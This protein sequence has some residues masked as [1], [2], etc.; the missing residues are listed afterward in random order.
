[1]SEKKLTIHTD[2]GS[3]G[4]PGPAACAFIILQDNKVIAENAVSLGIATNNHAEYQGVINALDHLINNPNLLSQIDSVEFKL[5]SELVVRQL[6]GQYKV[7][8]P[9][10]IPLY[11]KVVH[12]ISLINQPISFSH[13]PR[14]ENHLADKKLNLE[15]DSKKSLS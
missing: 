3:R 2:G 9:D 15:L 12:Q 11:Q 10:I 4:N 7:K 6:K 1:M 5:D 13:I 8:H 14:S